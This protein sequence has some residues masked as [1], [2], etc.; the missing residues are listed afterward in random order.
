VVRVLSAVLAFLF[1]GL[2]AG[3]GFLWLGEA[4]GW[5]GVHAGPSGPVWWRI[6]YAVV[7]LL[8]TPAIAI[9]CA[10]AAWRSGAK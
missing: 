2:M 7:A 6:T 8:G 1:C 10:F 5:F 4:T 3:L 9:Y